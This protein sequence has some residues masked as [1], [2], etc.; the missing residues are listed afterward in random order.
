MWI[1]A[2]YIPKSHL[3]HNYPD[4]DLFPILKLFLYITLYIGFHVET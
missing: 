3:L 1:N 4:V 2:L